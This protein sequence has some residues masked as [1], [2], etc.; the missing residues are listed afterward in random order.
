MTMTPR[1]R[2]VE[3]LAFVVASFAMAEVRADAC[4]V[5]ARVDLPPCASW[6]WPMSDDHWH[7]RITN[8]CPNPIAYKVDVVN[9]AD[10]SGVVSG[11]AYKDVHINTNFINSSIRSVK[12]CTQGND[13]ASEGGCDQT[14]T[15]TEVAERERAEEQARTNFIAEC[16]S[17]WNDAPANAACTATVSAN[18]ALDRC[19]LSSVSCDE[20]STGG[21]ITTYG[22]LTKSVEDIAKARIC[23]MGL[24]FV[25]ECPEDAV[26]RIDREILLT[27]CETSWDSSPASD[28]C[29]V[30]SISAN[31]E[32]GECHL[33]NIRCEHGNGLVGVYTGVVLGAPKKI[34]NARFCETL[35]IY[36]EGGHLS[37]IDECPED[38]LATI[39]EIEQKEQE[40][41]EARSAFLESCRYAWQED[42]EIGKSC[43][44][45]TLDV[46]D[47]NT[48]CLFGG[49]SCLD[50]A[51]NHASPIHV[52]NGDLSLTVG[53]I[54]LARNCGTEGTLVASGDCTY[55]ETESQTVDHSSS[56]DALSYVCEFRWSEFGIADRCSYQEL[57]VD[58]S[59]RQCTIIHPECTDADGII[60]HTPG[61]FSFDMLDPP[62]VEVCDDGAFVMDREC[63]A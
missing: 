10:G 59:T 40:R 38:S 54:A 6:S 43:T 4:G 49:V 46:N 14:E 62:A 55:L 35:D 20:T 28:S 8:L 27:S 30:E 2:I 9:A 12:C 45:T 11:N 25:D 16:E 24:S 31:Q 7:I 36:P 58:Q 52:D 34:A 39:K 5:D 37:L 3:I 47:D 32:R 48:R 29:T 19:T 60:V 44:Y 23:E 17:A 53:E 21:E 26:K 56:Q 51:T 33:N 42:S 15:V 61:R 13:Y 1:Y 57:Q 22:D 50:A 41:R 63:P 18:D